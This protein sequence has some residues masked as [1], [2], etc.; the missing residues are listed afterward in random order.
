[1]GKSAPLKFSDGSTHTLEIVKQKFQA[2][3]E[4]ILMF[5]AGGELEEYFKNIPKTEY[6]IVIAEGKKAQK[7]PAE[8]AR[9][10]ADM[11]GT[12][13]NQIDIGDIVSKHDD[14]KKVLSAGHKTLRFPRGRW[15]ADEKILIRTPFSI[16]GEGTNFTNLT[17]REI[18]IAIPE[19]TRMSIE[20]I[21]FNM[22]GDESLIRVTGGN[23]TFTDV[24]FECVRVKSEKNSIVRF[25]NCEFYKISPALLQHD[26]SL[27]EYDKDTKFDSCD[28]PHLES[29]NTGDSQSAKKNK[30]DKTVIASV[31]NK[32]SQPAGRDK[33]GTKIIKNVKEFSCEA[34]RR[35][36]NE[37]KHKKTI[38]AKGTNKVSQVA[39][40]E[41]VRAEI[42]NNDKA[43]RG[44]VDVDFNAI[45]KEYLNYRILREDNLSCSSYA[46]EDNMDQQFIATL[47]KTCNISVWS[48]LCEDKSVQAQVLMCFCALNGV[49][50]AADVS[51]ARK[52]I[53]DACNQMFFPAYTVL[54]LEMI[55][56][57]FEG[58]KTKALTYLSKAAENNY[59]P[60]QFFLA[61]NL[62]GNAVNKKMQFYK[63]AAG[64]GISLAAYYVW[65]DFDKQAR[66][67]ANWNMV[68][69]WP[70]K[71]KFSP[72]NY[73]EGIKWLLIAS[74]LGY[75]AAQYKLGTFYSKG[76]H[77]AKDT[78]K[79][80]GLYER[81]A[82][83]GHKEAI[84]LL[85]K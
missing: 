61:C 47:K 83:Q 45:M 28:E 15:P 67:A 54:G 58:G 14:L 53:R 64:N 25:E 80:I 73:D 55:D 65:E 46:D 22:T 23:V 51:V 77:V 43:L 59:G 66:S 81:A 49:G 26:T 84:K 56:N 12:T 48:K 76:Q 1:L 63:L 8:I 70:F 3:P 6:C 38:I 18:E 36:Y 57:V 34:E 7:P 60:A 68:N 39:G 72:T 16:C 79:A 2:E 85:R 9:E 31:T 69:S 52:F 41:K 29:H 33:V 13:F 74:N 78:K 30:H 82:K 17:I 4:R 40:R 24:R 21:A 44:D 20:R 11:L 71:A 32:M 35:F 75:A 37:E 27:I 42:I 62:P 50:L 10:L 5:I 19:N